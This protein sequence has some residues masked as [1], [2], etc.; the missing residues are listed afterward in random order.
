MLPG[1]HGSPVVPSEYTVLFEKTVYPVVAGMVRTA[2][3]A[4]II[5]VG[6][7]LVHQAIDLLRNR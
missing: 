4:S 1:W 7:S 5:P 2:L 6:I 3:L